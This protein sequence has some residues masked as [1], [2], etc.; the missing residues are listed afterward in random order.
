MEKYVLIILVVCCGL[1]GAVGQI[2][3]KL[4]APA[5]KL[6]ASILTNHYVLIGLFLYACATVLFIYAL[7][8]GEVSLLYP[9]L[10]TSYIWVALLA[11]FF[12]GEKVALANWAGIVLVVAGVALIAR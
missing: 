10:A 1:L 5:A 9:V 4:G 3:V 11:S 12:L 8:F 2:H 7:K 6:N